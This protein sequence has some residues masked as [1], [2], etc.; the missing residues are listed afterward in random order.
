MREWRKN[1]REENNAVARRW[2]SKNRVKVNAFS[3]VWRQEN[4]DIMATH[5]ANRRVAMLSRT[6]FW[7][8]RDA[9]WMVSQAYALA[10]QRTKMFGFAW[11]V[12][13]VVPLQGKTVSGLHVPWNL[14]VIP[15]T[16]NLRKSN[17]F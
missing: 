6:P 10:V 16:D 12:D 5:K 3:R 4:K 15:G 2:A 11:H 13:H 9:R 17:R 1:R 7:L 14:Q 8:S